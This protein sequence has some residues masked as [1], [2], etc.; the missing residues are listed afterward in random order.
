MPADNTDT[1]AP[2]T[3]VLFP[4]DG[5]TFGS[6][7]TRSGPGA[8]KLAKIGVYQVSFQVSVS[9]AGQ[10]CLTLNTQEQ[11]YTVVGRATGTCQIVGMFLIATTTPNSILTVRNPATETTALTITLISGGTKPVSAHV[12]ITRLN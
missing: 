5:P 2:G 8:F 12:I 3:D 7:V 9:E 6:D 4:N 1:V 10:L 11:D